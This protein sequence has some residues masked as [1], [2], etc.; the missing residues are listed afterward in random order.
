MNLPFGLIYLGLVIGIGLWALRRNRDARD[1]FLAGGRLGL[2]P[3]AFATMASVMS[4]FVFVGGPGL[5][6]QVGMGSFWITISSSFTGALMAWVLARPLHRMALERG[7]LTIPDVVEARFSCR[8]SSGLASLAILL[9]AVGY[10]AVQVQAL[11]VVLSSILGVSY[12][13]AVLIG[14]GVLAFYCISGGMVASVYTDVVQ[15]AIMIWA[16]T[17]V[18]FFSLQSGGGLGSITR[19]IQAN[20]PEILSPWGTVGA[21]GALSWFF[22]FAVG[23][24]GQP[25]VVN[26]FMMIR[27]LRVLRYF[28]LIL[29]A[30]MLLCGLIWLGVG[31]AVKAHVLQGT[32]APLSS[33]DAAVTVFLQQ[34]AP[35]WLEG[36][37]YVGII[38]AIMSTSDSFANVGAAALARD[39]PKAFGWPLKEELLR[40]RLWTLALFLLA[41]LFSTTMETLVAYLGIVSFATFAAALAPVLAVGLN[42][43]GATTWGVRA[44]LLVGLLASISLETIRRMGAYSLEVSPGALALAI[45]LLVFLGVSYWTGDENIKSRFRFFSLPW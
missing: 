1:F 31:M 12:S 16:T 13:T 15:G 9:G 14:V 41:V 28:P 5:F 36:L 24:L 11:G 32:L 33:P 10:L 22:L 21:L 37:V 17:M 27:D 4:G 6:Y 42:W 23:S 3:L 40:G 2:L 34:F 39:L 18:F 26:K 20:A 29:A 35:P 38:A 30:T 7:C 44:S 8:F 19:T 25:H 45:S 43:E